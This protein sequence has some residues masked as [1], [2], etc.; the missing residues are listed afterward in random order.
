MASAEA[1]SLFGVDGL[2]GL[3]VD[4]KAPKKME[5]NGD[6]AAGS[7]QTNEFDQKLGVKR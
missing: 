5:N 4:G 7:F 1:L 2:D 6:F 3:N